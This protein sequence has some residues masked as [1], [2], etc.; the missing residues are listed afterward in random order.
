LAHSVR[1]SIRNFPPSTIF[2][3]SESKPPE[4]NKGGKKS[5]KTRESPG[6]PRKTGKEIPS[7]P[8]DEPIGLG[9]LFVEFGLA[10]IDYLRILLT[11]MKIGWLRRPG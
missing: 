5:V 9:F 1:V 3:K 11:K 6:I 4:K 7:A 10:G 8:A 2:R